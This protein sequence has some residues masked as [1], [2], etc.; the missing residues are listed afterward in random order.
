MEGVKNNLDH[1]EQQINKKKHHNK[2]C[3]EQD[4]RDNIGNLIKKE[5]KGDHHFKK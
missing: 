1:W 3:V 4:G 5:R 2:V